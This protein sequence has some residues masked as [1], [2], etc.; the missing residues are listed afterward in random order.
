MHSHNPN[1]VPKVGLFG[2]LSAASALTLMAG[3]VAAQ[4]ETKPVAVQPAEGAAEKAA[5][6]E[7]EAREW[8]GEKSWWEWERATGDWG[9]LRTKMED[10]GIDFEASY[11]LDWQTVL[12]GGVNHRAFTTSYLDLNATLDMEKLVGIPGGSVYA[13]FVFSDVPSER[14]DA[15][16]FQGVSN[17]T[18]GDNRTQ[19]S[20]LWY[21]QWFFDQKLRVKAG[22]IDGWK[23]FAY[24]E[25]AEDFLHGAT[26]WFYTI[27]DFPAWS[28]P[29]TGV[30]AFFYPTENVYVG[31]GFFDGA[32]ADGFRTGT[33][34]PATFFSNSKSDSW[35]W[36]GEAGL[37]W[38]SLG[39]M[40]SGRAAAGISYHTAEFE[41]FDGGTE[42]GTAGFYILAEQQLWAAGASDEEKERG[43]FVYGQYGH[44]DDAV[45]DVGNQ[46]S[47][48]LILKGTFAG[49]DGDS[50]GVFASWVDL[51][52]DP[53][54][55]YAENETALELMYKFAVTPAVNVRPDVQF[56]FNPSG[57]PA[58][59]TAIVAGMRVE[60]T[61]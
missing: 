16:D 30:T 52:D 14:N 48:G 42:S 60:I 35:F 4:P 10:A 51:S 1:S 15:G 43:L 39:G 12:D 25:Q 18:T 7:A 34:G 61:F 47:A 55:G 54:A 57:D 21:Q 33:R 19:L 6:G 31:A 45:L 41:R 5:E 27:A 26:G 53:D 8:F 58:L 40:G 3:L 46:L 32:T 56:I 37:T 49:R 38:A 36:I 29:A 50:A 28:D 9:G 11:S 20:E 44:A 22:K 23:D 17:L 2:A 59:D 13:G 24:V